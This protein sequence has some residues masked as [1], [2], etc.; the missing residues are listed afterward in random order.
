[1]RRSLIGLARGR[2]AALGAVAFLLATGCGTT[3]PQSAFRAAAQNGQAGGGLGIAPAQTAGSTVGSGGS[4]PAS[5]RGSARGTGG[6]TGLPTGGG[7]GTNGVPPAFGPGITPTT[8]YIGA[9]YNKNQAAAN[10]SIGGGGAG[11]SDARAAY[12]VMFKLANQQGGVA[13]RK[14]VP[15]YYGFDATSTQTA[16]QQDHAACA[17]WTQDNKIFILLTG[18]SPDDRQCAKNEG[19]VDYWGPAGSNSLPETF[20]QNPHYVEITGLNLVRLG[21]VTI[22]GL[23]SQGYFERGSRIGIVAW[24]DPAYREA[25]QQGFIPA[26]Q[27]HGL[28]L[29]LPPAYIHAPQNAQDLGV[30]SADVSNT[31]LKFKTNTIDHVMLLDGPVGVCEGGCMGL[32][33]LNQAKSQHYYPRYGM[34]DNNLPVDAYEAGYYPA[35][36]LKGTLVVTGL[37]GVKAEDAGWHVNAARQRCENLMR[38]NGVDMSSIDA[39]AAAIGACEDIWFLQAVAAKLGE[40]PLTADNFMAAVNALGSSFASDSAYGV[41]FSATQHDGL[42]EVRDMRFDSSCN[43]FKY[44]SD[45]YPI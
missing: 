34:N 43:C 12:N 19:A 8:I 30:S 36:E 11:G 4:G 10:S 44:T 25:V 16:E 13:G 15:I 37:D 27:R 41:H 20:Q 1:V 5:S 35:D 7:A 42:A 2:L 14:L 24:D 39:Y 21:Q 28:K 40:A 9:V 6:P 17:K 33:F 29:A 18:Q 45:P 26:L 3:V 23:T 22:D 32:E 38:R 31:V